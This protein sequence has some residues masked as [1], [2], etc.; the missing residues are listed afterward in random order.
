MHSKKVIA[1]LI[2]LCIATESLAGEKFMPLSEIKPGMRG[3]AKTVFTGTKIEEFELEILD[4]IPNF[5]AKRSLILAKL[6]G[7][8]IEK[9][10]VVAGMS[11]SPVYIDGKLVGALSYR[12]GI[13]LKEPIT[14]ITPI[15]EMLEIFDREKYRNQELASIQS[16]DSK[17]L[18]MAIGVRETNWENFIPPKFPI[19]KSV[20]TSAS[21]ISPLEL[22]LI[23]SGFE[24]SI[25]ELSSQIFNGLGFKILQSGGTLSTNDED[26]S[27]QL[28]PGDAVSV[29]IVDGDFGLQATGT[30][31]Y[32]DGD[33][34]LGLGHPFFNS[35]AVGLPMGRAKILTTLSSLMASTKLAAQ[36]EIVGTIHQDRATGIMGVSGEAPKIIPVRMTFNSEIQEP[37]EF[38]FRVAQDRSIHSLTPLVLRIVL[39]NALESARLSTGNQTLR[40]NGRIVLK[41]HQDIQLQNYYAGSLPGSLVTDAIEATGEISAIL[42]SLLS[43]NFE[44]PEIESIDL[45]FTS[46]PQKSLATVQRIEID[47]SVVKPGDKIDITVTLKEY[48]GSEHRIHHT[49]DIPDEITSK[50]IAIFT[51]SGS[52]L[53]RVEFRNAPQKFSPKNFHQLVELL[54][55]RR[56]NNF[57]FFQIRHS[58]KGVLIEGEELPSLPPSI[59]TVMNSQKTS[60][61]VLSLRD[62]ILIEDSVQVNYSISGGRTVWLRVES[63]DE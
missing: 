21:S 44:L 51:G 39:S 42:G 54:K 36:T 19:L 56:K 3:I 1:F 30:V 47:K 25:V 9:T 17:Y 53:T 35:G 4:I 46:L 32:R 20:H 60:G 29:V 43:N 23:F 12:M 45:N 41:G 33:K 27:S 52:A 61:N 34:I 5:R 26:N 13:F 18:E 10:G 28:E 16:Y 62:R 63:K 31:T 14:G 6:L 50:R 11:G 37:V 59:R 24:N 22:P 8:K 49:L 38:N 15:E 7:D 58:N 2:L 57:L 55:K 40:L 48:Q